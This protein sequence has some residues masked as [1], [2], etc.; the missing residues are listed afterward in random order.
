M[1]QVGSAVYRCA[2]EGATPSEMGTE[3]GVLSD[4]L[5]RP[6]MSSPCR[7]SCFDPV[8]GCLCS[9]LCP[10]P[11]PCRPLCRRTLCHDCACGISFQPCV[12]L[13]LLYAR[14]CVSSFPPFAPF[15]R[16]LDCHQLPSSSPT[17]SFQK[18]ASQVEH[19]P[20]RESAQVEE[21]SWNSEP[22]SQPAEE[23]L[24]GRTLSIRKP[25]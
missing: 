14:P 20:E 7:P 13:S 22:E 8:V 10:C 17:P 24:P 15:S 2:Q 21:W 11:F 25:T 3:A 6:F 18:Q 16:D 1:G 5:E 19:E 23:C 4:L 12:F 9:C